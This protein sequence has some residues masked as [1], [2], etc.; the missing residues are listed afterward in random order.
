MNRAQ[1][2]VRHES[3]G[4]D[5]GGSVRVFAHWGSGICR[6]RVT[7]AALVLTRR[8][9]WPSI[10]SQLTDMPK[11]RHPSQ[12]KPAGLFRVTYTIGAGTANAADADLRRILA[13]VPGIDNRIDD[14]ADSASSAL[15]GALAAHIWAVENGTDNESYNNEHDHSHKFRKPSLA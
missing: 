13:L 10:M 3:E 6:A 5:S 12:G 8:C 1:Y 7:V 9:P 4:S 11:P 2:V 15:R 14:A